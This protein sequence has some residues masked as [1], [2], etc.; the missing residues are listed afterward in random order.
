MSKIDRAR[1]N[2]QAKTSPP[3]ALSALIGI[4]TFQ[5]ERPVPNAPRWGGARPNPSPRSIV[6]ETQPDVL[7]RIEVRIIEQLDDLFARRDEGFAIV[8]LCLA[9]QGVDVAASSG[10]CRA[11][12]GRSS[13]GTSV[14][15]GIPLASVGIARRLFPDRA[16]R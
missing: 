4:D 16:L 2:C 1:S 8:D 10:D 12:V 3:D 7:S 13:W 5:T 15:A 11:E 9:D 14:R 6:D